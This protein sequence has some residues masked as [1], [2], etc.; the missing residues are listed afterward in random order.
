MAAFDKLRFYI[1]KCH[2]GNNNMR[3]CVKMYGEAHTFSAIGKQVIC[4][5]FPS[6]SG[7][8]IQ[9]KAPITF[10]LTEVCS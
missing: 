8:N 9:V 5:E 6:I 4:L 2:K 7:S 10:V 3:I 1:I